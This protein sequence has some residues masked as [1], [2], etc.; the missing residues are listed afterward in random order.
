MGVKGKRGSTEREPDTQKNREGKET[1]SSQGRH[2]HKR[3]RPRAGVEGNVQIVILG[4]EGFTSRAHLSGIESGDF[5]KTSPSERAFARKGD[6]FNSVDTRSD[7]TAGWRRK[8][9]RTATF[10]TPQ[11]GAALSLGRRGE[12]SPPKGGKRGGGEKM[13]CSHKKECLL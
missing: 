5:T 8:R 9:G 4:N 2:S 13:Q 11:K 12:A 10:R 1:L 6:D 3:G 7:K